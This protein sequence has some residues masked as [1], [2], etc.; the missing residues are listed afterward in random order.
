MNSV[1]DSTTDVVLLLSLVFHFFFLFLCIFTIIVKIDATFRFSKFYR[2]EKY[3]EFLL[4]FFFFVFSSANS[5]FD[6]SL[7]KAVLLNTRGTR[8]MIELAKEM[9]QLVLF[10]H[11]STSY[12]HLDEK[13][14][15]SLN[16]FDKEILFI[17]QQVI[18]MFFIS[19]F[20]A[21]LIFARFYCF[22]NSK[23][24]TSRK[25][26]SSTRWPTQNHQMC[27]VDGRRGCRSHDRK[28]S[29]H[30]SKYLRLYEGLVRGPRRGG[31]ASHSSGYSSARILFF[32]LLIFIR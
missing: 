6:E 3:R 29:R 9:K 15:F 28:N 8:N 14:F 12:C 4:T 17:Q 19:T 21:S 11:I 27:R 10:A 32:L 7:K 24:D 23:L 18:K 30:I 31:D 20:F 22:F 16:F 1:L 2:T 25:T 13:V 26:L 5:R